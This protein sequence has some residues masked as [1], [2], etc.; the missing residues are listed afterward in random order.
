MPAQ[1]QHTCT[2]P[3]Q[4]DLEKLAAELAARGLQA[5]LRTPE[6][7]LPY[8]DVVNPAVTFLT[9]K[10]Y[11]QADAYWFGWAE[12]IADCDDVAQAADSLA[13]VLSA[14]ATPGE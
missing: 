5:Q 7:K 9:E 4:A 11:A 10:V 2:D 13:N 12:K 8:L 14:R 3:E 1:R 6:G